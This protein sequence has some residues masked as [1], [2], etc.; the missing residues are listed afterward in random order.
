MEKVLGNG[1]NIEELFTYIEPAIVT[2]NRNTN[3]TKISDMNGDIIKRILYP[4]KKCHPNDFILK[5]FKMSVEF[6][7]KLNYRLC[8][9]IP[10]EGTNN[11]IIK[12]LY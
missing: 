1:V 3:H 5:G 7:E 11:Y 10:D 9:N 12:N 8:P 6:E 4:M 2:E